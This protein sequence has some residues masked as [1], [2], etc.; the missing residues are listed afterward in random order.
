MAVI[1]FYVCCCLL[2]YAVCV[3]FKYGCFAFAFSTAVQEAK[4]GAVR[5]EKPEDLR[6]KQAGEGPLT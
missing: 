4:S 2:G 5:E 6:L 1:L 3:F